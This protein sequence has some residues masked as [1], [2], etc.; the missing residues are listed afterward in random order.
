[1]TDLTPQEAAESLDSLNEELFDG[2]G[3]TLKFAASYMR[4][5]ASGEY[6]PVVH[7]HWKEC[8]PGHDILF[9][10]SNCGRI[11]ST[12]WGCCEDEDTQGNNGCD[13]TE[14]W[15]NCP[16]CG[17]LMDGKDDSNEN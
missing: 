9:E 11:I 10:C 4:K 14:E 1:M 8:E 13:P 3:D 2:T 12:G 16:S 7:A 5:I 15:L 17:A 6:A